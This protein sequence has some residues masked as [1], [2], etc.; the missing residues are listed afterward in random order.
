MFHAQVSKK[1][2]DEFLAAI[3]DRKGYRSQFSAYDGTSYYVGDRLM[4]RSLNKMC[5]HNKYWIAVNLY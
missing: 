5:G 4:G 1:V 3:Q 2:F